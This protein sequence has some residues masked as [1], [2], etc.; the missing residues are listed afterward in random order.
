MLNKS[1]RQKKIIIAVIDQKT[2]RQ[3]ESAALGFGFTNFSFA[4]EC[5]DIYRI[6]RPYIDCPE[7][8]GMVIV[9]EQLPGGQVNEMCKSLS[10]EQDGNALPFVILRSSETKV[11]NDLNRREYLIY[12]L[13]KPV[14]RSEL[15]ILIELLILLKD[16]R[17]IKHKQQEKLVTELATRKLLDAKLKYLVAHDELTGLMNRNNLEQ[18]IRLSF[19][20]NNKLQQN[21]ALLLIDLDRFSLINDLEGFEVADKLIINLVSHIRQQFKQE[22]L[23]ARIDSD[24]FCLYFENITTEQAREIAENIR[25]G[26][27]EYRFDAGNVCY[28]ISASIGVAT[29]Q[30]LDNWHP[31]ELISRAHQACYLAKQNGR[32]M[33]WLY[34]ENDQAIKERHRDV[35]WVPL[36]KDALKAQSFFLMYQPVVNLRTGSVSH[37]EVLIRMRGRDNNVISPAEFI[38]VAERMG[39]IHSIDLWVVEK[40]I[41]FLA[42]LP[43]ESSHISLSIN[44]SGVAFQ[45]CSLLPTI[46]RKLE[47]SWVSA[48]RITFEITETAAVDNFE[49]TRKMINDIRSL[50]CHFALDDFGAG[51][52]SFNYLKKFPVDFVKIDGQFIQNLMNDDTDQVLVR[53]MSEIAHQLGKKTIAEFIESPSVI[54]ILT[55][56]GIDYGQGYIFGQPSL[57]LL[58]EGCVPLKQLLIE[59][60]KKSRFLYN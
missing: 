35:Y 43:S 18:H 46:K 48:K 27:N 29:V 58:E 34:N 17:Y 50:G 30:A 56:L 10:R 22:A 40:A 16:E 47:M 44:L 14:Q 12:E 15:N 54:K 20:R 52:C 4:L 11:F 25:K 26:V 41:D 53:S 42:A 3:I 9:D 7:E 32:N 31:E 37:Y 5:G 28:N 6:I 13:I 59:G 8:L 49:Q 23:F 24:E 57:E 39:L 38:P 2:V 51:F 60:D 1:Q 45:D 55:D 21:G 19:A 36:I 33:V